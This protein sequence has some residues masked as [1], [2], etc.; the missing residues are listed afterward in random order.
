MSSMVIRV[1]VLRTRPA[2]PFY[3]AR[4]K[5]PYTVAAPERAHPALARGG[6][7]VEVDV[8]RE[9][10]RHLIVPPERG[11]E[12]EP[13]VAEPAGSSYSKSAWLSILYT[14]QRHAKRAAPLR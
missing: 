10:P 5:S 13:R 2:P 11:L 1:G 14:L 6:I 9:V 7:R 12:S 8:H 3:G 4:Q